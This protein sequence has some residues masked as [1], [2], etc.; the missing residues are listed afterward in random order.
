MIKK[1]LDL[2]LQPLAKKYLSK[3]DLVKKKVEYYYQ[4]KILYPRI[5]VKDSLGK[6]MVELR[7]IFFL[8]KL[9]LQ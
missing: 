2:G 5:L 9:E 4:L 3:K 1:F 8:L 7:F 6:L